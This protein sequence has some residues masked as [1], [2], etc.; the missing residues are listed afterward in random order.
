MS[1]NL[2]HKIFLDVVNASIR[3]PLFRFVYS[4]LLCG[5]VALLFAGEYTAILSVFGPCV[6]ICLYHRHILWELRLI[7][8]RLQCMTHTRRWT[9]RA[10][11]GLLYG[12]LP[13]KIQ[14]SGLSYGK[15]DKGS[16]M[17]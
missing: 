6:F 8:F 13:L 16:L 2:R 5:A 12:A 9:Y 17:A 1:N 7:W 10:C 3:S 14:E 4:C 11:H 15:H